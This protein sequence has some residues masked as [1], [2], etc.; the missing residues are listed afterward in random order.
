MLSPRDIRNRKNQ[1]KK[2]SFGGGYDTAEVDRALTDLAEQ[3]ES[4]QDE[5]RA[6]EARV[7]ELEEKLKHYEKVELALQEALETARDTARRTEEAADRKARL[8]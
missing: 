2:K 1:F 4:V 8:I 3:W 5:R 7:S 6:A